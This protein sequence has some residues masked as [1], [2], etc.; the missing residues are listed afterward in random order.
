MQVDVSIWLINVVSPDRSAVQLSTI[1]GCK[2]IAVIDPL[3]TST[4][5]YTK[6]IWCQ[7]EM[8]D[9]EIDL[10]DDQSKASLLQTV[11]V[12]HH[13]VRTLCAIVYTHCWGSSGEISQ[14]VRCNLAGN[15]I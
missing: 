3:L 12:E 4:R 11:N 5:P 9:Y 1:E 6:W 10:L 8:L 7:C 15:H 13:T 2:V 14:G